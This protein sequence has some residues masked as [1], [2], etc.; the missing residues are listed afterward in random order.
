VLTG[1]CT[2]K[3]NKQIAYEL[4]LSEGTVKIH[5][6]AVFKVF[7]VRNRTQAVIAAQAGA[8]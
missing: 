3:S 5:I 4:G 6:N 7:G 8:S 2:G 1:L